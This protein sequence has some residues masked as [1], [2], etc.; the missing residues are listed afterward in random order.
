MHR[1]LPPEEV[2]PPAL[3]ELNRPSY[4]QTIE[5]M[6]DAW[7][8]SLDGLADPLAFI[9]VRDSVGHTGQ[10]PGGDDQ[11]LAVAVNALEALFERMMASWLHIGTEHAGLGAP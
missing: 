3:R 10:V 5:S 8:V 1:I 4:R 7:G 2:L 9:S 11:G 6:V